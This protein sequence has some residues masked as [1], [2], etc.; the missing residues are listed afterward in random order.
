MADRSTHAVVG[1]QCEYL[2]Q[3]SEGEKEEKEIREH[4]FGSE[5]TASERRGNT[6]KGSKNFYL[7]VRANIWPTLC[8][9]CHIR[10]R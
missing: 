7:K 9:M 10:T 1:R 4:R 2:A 5:G 8:H 6:S 3:G